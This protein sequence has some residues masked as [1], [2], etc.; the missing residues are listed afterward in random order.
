MPGVRYLRSIGI[1]GVLI[2]L[3]APADA[4]T[5]TRRVSTLDLLMEHTL[6]FHGQDVVVHADAVGETVL[7]YL[8]SDDARLLALDV[9]PPLDGTTE[10]LEVVG[11]FYD[12]GRLEPTDP[13]TSG[14]PFERLADSLLDK[15]WAR[16]RGAIG[17][18]G[19]VV[20]TRHSRWNHHAP[21]R[22]LGPGG[23]S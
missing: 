15:P 19:R 11:T 2:S 5:P 23:A 18:R 14:L 1:G 9:P 6:F 20:S 7:T 4:Q 12:V 17:H 22:R 16:R 3:I 21:F 10:R 13:R 8:V